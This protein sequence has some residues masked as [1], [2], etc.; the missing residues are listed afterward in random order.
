[1]SRTDQRRAL[2]AAQAPGGDPSGGTGQNDIADRQAAWAA[3]S[4]MALPETADPATVDVAPDCLKLTYRV[5]TP[6]GTAVDVLRTI[7]V[8]E[9]QQGVAVVESFTLRCAQ[10]LSVD[11]EIRRPFA[12]IPK[13]TV[14]QLEL[15]CPLRNG[16]A[17]R[18]P[19][20]QQPVRR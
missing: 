15:V 18:V 17:K 8:S 1:M 5:S 7:T 6:E 11:V 16:L 3:Q 4:K 9:N 13:R 2:W 12:L 10:R 20:D 14:G 19:V